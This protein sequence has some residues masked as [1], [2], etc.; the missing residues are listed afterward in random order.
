MKKVQL[1]DRLDSYSFEM[2]DIE[3][4]YDLLEMR[5]IIESEAAR[6][7][8]WRASEEDLNLIKTALDEFTEKMKNI[9]EI[10]SEADYHF[11]KAIVKSAYNPFLLQ[12]MENLQDL[13]KTS[14]EF[15]LKQ[16]VGIKRKREQIYEEHYQIY[17]SIVARDGEAAAYH[18]K[19]HL[20]NVRIKMG[21]RR[22]KA[23]PKKMNQ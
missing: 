8:A 2:I 5:T 21:D 14:L 17:K 15:T 22:I 1:A 10:G 6:F 11:H 4:I 16:N 18:M 3:Q 20:Y 12:T 23:L 7:A 19:R 13:Y 9:N